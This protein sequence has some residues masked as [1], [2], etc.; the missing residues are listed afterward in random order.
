MTT[1][2]YNNCVDLY[3][4][5]L[6]RFILKNIKDIHTAQDIVQDTFMKFWE[7][8]DTV[9]TG[10]T[11]SYLFTTAYRTMIDGIRKNSRNEV[12]DEFKTSKVVFNHYNDLQE[13]LHKAIENLP[14][15]QKSVILLRDYEGYSYEEIA[16]IT[17]LTESQVKGYIFRARK[18]LKEYIGSIEAVL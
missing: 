17:E 5:N 2:E 9:N 14:L 16:G 11:K 13:I 3:S 18:F 1:K 10:K 12:V 6:Y 4:D 8:K 15:I 7:K